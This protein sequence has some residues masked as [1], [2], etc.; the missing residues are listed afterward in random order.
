MSP[1]VLFAAVLLICVIINTGNL[2]QSLIGRP[3]ISM[4]L[5][6]FQSNRCQM[7]M[8]DHLCKIRRFGTLRFWSIQA[9]NS[10]VFTRSSYNTLQ[11]TKQAT[12]LRLQAQIACQNLSTFQD[13]TSMTHL[14]PK[15]T[16]L[17]IML[18]GAVSESIMSTSCIY[19]ISKAL[20]K[21]CHDPF[22]AANL[23]Q[24][25]WK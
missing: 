9:V 4:L 1:S 10:M 12:C 7:E 15:R 2:E 23:Q 13:Q 6:F 17:N 3:I 14:T 19:P 20:P 25:C 22:T 21:L 8:C 16:R 18:H 5:W 24:T 11:Q